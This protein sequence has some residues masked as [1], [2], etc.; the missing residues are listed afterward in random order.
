MKLAL[1]FMQKFNIFSDFAQIWI[2]KTEFHKC[3]QYQISSKPGQWMDR[4]TEMT[5]PIGGFCEYANAPKNRN[6][7][8]KVYKKSLLQAKPSFF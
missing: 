1:L 8:N 3:L 5:K 4:Q 2:F 7:L 6:L